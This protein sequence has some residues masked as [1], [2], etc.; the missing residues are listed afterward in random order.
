MARWGEFERRFP[1]YVYPVRIV[2]AATMAPLV[3]AAK[4]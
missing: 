2:E 4:G 3:A 1:I